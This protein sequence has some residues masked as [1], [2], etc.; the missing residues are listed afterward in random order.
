VKADGALGHPKREKSVAMLAG[1][2]GLRRRA[3]L[4]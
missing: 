4:S 2:G 1:F 3:R